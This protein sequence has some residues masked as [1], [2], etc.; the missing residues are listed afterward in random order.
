MY[1]A[2]IAP[3]IEHN[4]LRPMRPGDEDILIAGQAHS[5]KPDSGTRRN[6]LEPQ[7]QH[8]VC[9]MGG[10]M[11]LGGKLFNSAS[12]STGV[13]TLAAPF[14]TGEMLRHFY[15]VCSEPG[16]ASLDE[17]VFNTKGHPFRRWK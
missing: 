14:W 12:F 1:K 15:L 16:L 5:R 11:A 9:F 3:A 17:F 8:L 6:E 4:F 10:V 7:G 13:S 2:A